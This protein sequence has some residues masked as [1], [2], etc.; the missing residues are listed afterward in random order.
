LQDTQTPIYA[1]NEMNKKITKAKKKL[2]AYIG[3]C[4]ACKGERV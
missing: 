4:V 3:V 1:Y 2:F